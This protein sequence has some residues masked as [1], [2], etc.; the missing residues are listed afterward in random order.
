M[1]KA[2]LLLVV[3]LGSMQLV[4]AQNSKNDAVAKAVTRLTA[5]MISGDKNELNA[6]VSESL[7]YGHSGGHVEGKEEFVDKLTTGKSDF[8]TI[9]LSEQTINVIGKT[10]FVRHNLDATTN[11]G[12]KPATV[13]LKVLLVFMK[14]HGDW[15]LVARQAVKPH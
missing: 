1:K 3:V 14:E 8:V 11:D 7:S 10:A 2:I 5:A 12:G 6:S 4:S 15:K 13:N 9:N